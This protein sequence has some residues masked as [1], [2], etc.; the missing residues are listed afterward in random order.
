MS[1]TGTT[2]ASLEDRLLRRD[3]VEYRTRAVGPDAA[4]LALLIV[5]LS[6]EG[7][8]A[9]SGASLEP[10]DIVHVLLPLLGETGAEV[11]W[12]LGGRIGCQFLQP[13]DH[14][15]YAPLLAELRRR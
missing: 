7:L 10:G 9:R 3:E 2:L 8:M 13:I 6:R 14:A 11:R 15:D 5:N 12:A 4:S 1:V